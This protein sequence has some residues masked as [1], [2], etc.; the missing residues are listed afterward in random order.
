MA[1]PI[2][3]APPSLSAVLDAIPG[4]ALL[5][6]RGAV[7]EASW[8]AAARFGQSQRRLVGQSL[9][10]VLPACTAALRA[11]ER[12]ADHASVRVDLGGRPAVIGLVR[13]DA[14]TLLVHLGAEG[15]PEEYEARRHFAARQE[16]L[17]ALAAGI[18]H[19]VKNPLAAIRGAAELLAEL[20]HDPDAASLVDLIRA[21]CGRI[22]RNVRLLMDLVGPQ[23]VRASVIDLHPLLDAAWSAAR[24]RAPGDI[25]FVRDL[26]PSL[27]RVEADADRIGEALLNLLSNAVEAARSRVTVRT[28]V[29]PAAR[30]L[31]AG[32]DRGALVQIDVEDDGP[33]LD[34]AAVRRI[35]VPFHTTK[36]EGHGLGLFVARKA[37]DDHGGALL[38]DGRPGAGARF[39]L[40]LRERI[41]APQEAEAP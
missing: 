33:G 16:E 14:D 8:P 26:D 22:D 34:D 30:L 20:R 6:A 32:R 12:G 7:V 15:G 24:L 40:L 41:P 10:A 27:P 2:H 19:E 1:A 11:L 29:A 9:D 25:T 17:R 35:F 31:E 36:A 3:A 5:V 37:A 38:V 13:V 4:G 21:Q 39:S 23:V 18:A 28:R